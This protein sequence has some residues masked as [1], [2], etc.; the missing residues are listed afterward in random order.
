MPRNHAGLFSTLY[1]CS[2]FS[3]Y[4]LFTSE[5]I[6]IYFMICPAYQPLSHGCFYTAITFKYTAAGILIQ[7]C[8]RMIITQAVDSD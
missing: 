6:S 3:R 8:E 7:P 1:T 4:T 5:F 2:S